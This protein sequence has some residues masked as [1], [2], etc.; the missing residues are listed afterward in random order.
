MS[1]SVALKEADIHPTAVVSDG[2]EIGQGTRVGPYS[3]IGPNVKIG[4]GCL[5]HSHVV[6]TGRTTI[7]NNNTI[8]QFA[9]VGAE[10]QDLK[11]HNEPSE[12]VIG[13]NNTIREYVTLQPGTEGGGMITTIGSHNLFMVCSHI[14]HD[15][16]VGNHNVIANSAAISGHVEIGDHV[17]IGGLAGIHQFVRIGNHAFLAGGAKV[18]QDIPNYCLAQ[19]DRAVLFGVNVVGLKRHGFSLDDIR[20]IKIA[21]RRLFLGSGKMQDKIS[22]LIVEITADKTTVSPAIQ[23]FI[24]FVASSKRGIA[25]ASLSRE[26]EGDADAS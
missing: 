13:D 6:V 24:D 3:I 9:S 8:Y 26:N 1:L 14:G 15:C 18:T 7:G 12:L 25:T 5:I 16:K 4:A 2:A 23:E 22:A 21:Y 11:F 17:I 10:P 20:T 19:G